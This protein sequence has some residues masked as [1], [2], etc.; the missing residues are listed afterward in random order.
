MHPA[1]TIQISVLWQQFRV[2]EFLFARYLHD[3][4]FNVSDYAWEPF[5]KTECNNH[6]IIFQQSSTDTNNLIVTFILSSKQ[7]TLLQLKFSEYERY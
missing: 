7:L 4:W 3:Q 5:L 1:D 2:S 6:S